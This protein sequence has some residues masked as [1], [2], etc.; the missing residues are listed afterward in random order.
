M[1]VKNRKLQNCPLQYTQVHAGI[2]PELS[3]RERKNGKLEDKLIGD[4]NFCRIIGGNLKANLSWESHLVSGPKAI[5]QTIRRLLGSLHGIIHIMSQKAK[6]NIINSLVI[7]KLIYI[8]SLWGNTIESQVRKSQVTMN[9]AARLVLDKRK[10]TRQID[11]MKGCS[12]LNVRELTEFHFLIQLTRWEIP[13][14]LSRK[15][16][17]T[18]E[19]LIET[20][21][22]RLILTAEAWR[23]RTTEQWNNLPMDL[24]AEMSLKRFKIHMT[25]W[26]TDRREVLVDPGYPPD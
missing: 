18:E 13:V 26:I 6:L 12:W 16:Q 25:R 8:I 20:K 2:P 7:S 5:I 3:G 22:S 10:S 19:Y 17:V 4:S 21:P 24:R 1:L 23:S 9:T 11:L 14:N 15:F